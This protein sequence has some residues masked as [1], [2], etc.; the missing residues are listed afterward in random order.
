MT[1]IGEVALWVAFILALWGMVLG[2][3]GGRRGRGD[4]VLS[5]ER[6][7]YAV[8]GLLIVASGAIIAAFVSSTR[9]RTIHV[10]PRFKPRSRPALMASC[11]SAGHRPVGANGSTIQR[12]GASGPLSMLPTPMKFNSGPKSGG[13]SRSAP[14]ARMFQ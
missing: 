13:G 10:G 12:A 14:S 1:Q 11:S 2:F 5:A 6:A 7:V 9:P 3:A 8:F 4:W